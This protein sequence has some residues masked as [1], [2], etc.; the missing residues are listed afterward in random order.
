MKR[1]VVIFLDREEQE[2]FAATVETAFGFKNAFTKAREAFRLQRPLDISRFV[3]VRM[4][5]VEC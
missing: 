4:R 5:E 2:L 1:F 3:E